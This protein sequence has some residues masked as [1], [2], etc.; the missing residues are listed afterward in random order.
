M[1]RFFI[2][3]PIVAIVIPILTVILGVAPL[4]GLP[5]PQSPSNLPPVIQIPPTSPGTAALP[6]PR[7]Q[8]GAWAPG[9]WNPATSAL[10]RPL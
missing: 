9:A 7:A 8:T 5:V 6:T 1:T 3:R 4:V 2:D 10:G